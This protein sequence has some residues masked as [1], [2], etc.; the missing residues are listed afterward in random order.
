VD[1]IK[2]EEACATKLK[3]E[4]GMSTLLFKSPLDRLSPADVKMPPCYAGAEAGHMEREC[5]QLLTRLQS[6]LRKKA[7]LEREVYDAHNLSALLTDRLSE[8]S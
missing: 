1:T 5:A 6:E 8:Q 7:Q 3:R 2:F 4:L